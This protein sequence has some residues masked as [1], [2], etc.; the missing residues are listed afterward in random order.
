ML[1]S[2]S[3]S[4][5]LLQGEKRCCLG[6]LIPTILSLK[7]KL[8]D[9]LPHMANIIAVVLE[10]LDKR[11]DA[12]LSSH[13]AK[14]ATTTMPKFCL[15]WL[16]PE[17]R[18]DMKKALVEEATSLESRAPCAAEMSISPEVEESDGVFCL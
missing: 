11:F 8:S 14:M 9:K 18:E 7:S 1:Q 6:F 5:D 16:S 12:M 10:A 13:D 2:L 4:I 17:K 3:H 15:C